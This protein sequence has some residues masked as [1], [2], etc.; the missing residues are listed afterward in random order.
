M[1]IRCLS[2]AAGLLL[3]SLSVSAQDNQYTLVGLVQ[4]LDL[5]SATGAGPTR[6]Q[7]WFDYDNAVL[8]QNHVLDLLDATS[9]RCHTAKQSS[10]KPDTQQKGGAGQ[11]TSSIPEVAD[12]NTC[13]DKAAEFPGANDYI[14]FHVVNW[15][16]SAS[17]VLKVTKQNWYVYNVSQGWDTTAFTGLRI[18]G[19][20]QVYLYTIH[21]NLPAS[22]HFYEERYAIDEKHKTPAFLTH[23][24]GIGQLF[25]IQSTG[26]GGTASSDK[27]YAWR[28]DV[29]YVPADI[30]IT[31]TMV[32]LSNTSNNPPVQPD[33]AKNQGGQVTPPTTALGN[34]P[35]EAPT[36]APPPPDKKGAPVTPPPQP[37]PAKV[38]GAK[39][40]DT[41]G[42]AGAQAAAANSATLDAK[43]FD[44]EGKYHVD[45]SVAVP[46]TKISGL[47]YVQASDT[48]AAAKVDKQKIFALFD[49]YIK[50]VDIKNTILPKLP[51]LLM[52]VGLGSQPLKQALFGVGWGPVYA[53]FYA[54]LLLNTERVT[55][56]WK[57]GD[58]APT[59]V[60]GTTLVNHTCPEFSFGLNMSVGAISDAL[61]S[62]TASGTP[63]S[64]TTPS[65]KK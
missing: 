65:G 48:L 26:G 58:N 27:W 61:K 43:T 34:G 46:I 17:S 53:N 47:S 52:G 44:N 54:G 50:P 51:Y 6:Q 35:V 9:G 56:T 40:A 55:S 29:K 22:D 21:L 36:G 2:R 1:S 64:G 10:Q 5:S 41:A 63:A 16:G 11:S 32:D 20:K 3:I 7:A 31:P 15:G 49:Y 24:L 59:A 28:L 38:A 14:I 39:P 45:F 57:C 42:K 12:L 4:N 13:G 37:A 25:G 60:A 8:F 33:A 19:K 23:L 30:Q 18:F 62:K